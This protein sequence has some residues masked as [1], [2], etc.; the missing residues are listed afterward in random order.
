MHKL[1]SLLTLAAALLAFAP[2]AIAQTATGNIYGN[3]TDQ[4]GAVLPGVSVTLTGETGTRTTVSSAQGQFRLL[5]LDNGDY[6]LA[7]ELNG[8]KKAARKVHVTTGENVEINMQMS[9]SGIAETVEVSAETPL[10]DTKKRGTSTTLTTEELQDVPNARDPWGVLRT[11]P[12]VLV[13]RVNIAG[14]ENGQQAN[15]SSKGSAAADR[16][17]NLDGLNVT[18]MSATGSSPS[19]FDFG[20]FQEINVTTGGSDLTVQSGGMGINLVTKRG[21]NKFH[22]AARYL[23][24][25]NK[26]SFNN[27][28]SQLAG[29]P[30]LAGSGQANHIDQI[31]DYGAELGGPIIKDK[32]WFYGT[33]GKQD[34]R[35]R[36]LTQTPDKTLLPSYNVKLNWQATKDTM[37]SAFYFLGGKQK[38]GRDPGLPV[39]AQDSFLWNQDN[40]YSPDWPLP[41]GLWKL[42]INQTFSPNFYVSAKAAY[43]DTGF[44][45]QPRGGND[46]SYTADYVGGIATGSYYTYLSVRPQKSINV[47]GNYFFQG[48]GGSNELKFGFGFRDVTTNSVS[49]YNGNQIGGVI[50]SPT[51]V[52]ALL[53]RDGVVNYGGKYWSGYAG[54]TLTK[55]RWTVNAGVRFDRQTAKNLASDSPANASFASVLPAVSYAG[56]TSNIVDWNSLSPRVGLSYALDEG[57]KT[58]LRASYANY[59]EQLNFGQVAVDANPVSRGFLAY[60]WNDLNHDGVA[61]PNEVNLNNYLYSY[62]INPANPGAVGTTANQADRDRKPKRDQEA[63][64]GIDHELAP[65]FAVGAAYTFRYS[66]DYTYRPRLAGACSDPSNPTAATCPILTVGDYAPNAPVS[67]NGFTAFTYS[68]DA[69]LVA[70]GG[71]GRLRT[72]AP[73]YHTT[74]NGLELTAT[75]RMSNKW[76][77]RVAFSLNN[78]TE[79]WD[80]APFGV[81]QST[82]TTSGSPT[83]EERD[84]LVNGGQVAILSGGSGKAS[85]Y[86]SVKWQVYADALYNLPGGF[87][88]SGSLFARQGGSYPISLNLPAGA[89]GT[90]RALATAAIDTLRYP[91]L[92][93][94]DLRLA[95]TLKTGGSSSLTLSAEWFNVF[96]SG[97]VL[98]RYRFANSSAFTDTA[99][100]AEPGLGRIE[101]ILAPGIF[102][103][104]A[105]FTF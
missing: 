91:T 70:A 24:A 46:Q 84:P 40:A 73:G 101:E 3:V 62:N 15:T 48:L 23:L 20:A 7:F 35:L 87:D 31:S 53:W 10:V 55:G 21:T 96:N 60:Q 94:L 61:Q 56:D 95:K 99:A 9:V 85:F 65:N 37:V 104:G 80:T 2:L 8:F 97:T 74:F 75:K 22:G 71:A 25:H 39:T 43:Y 77:G 44:G 11:V 89:D 69:A 30:R 47:D 68:P 93:D 67:S 18:D 59:A 88:V 32:L 54:D 14:S 28:P 58:V 78:W 76:F 79:H 57:R 38:F 100:G 13:D 41:G 81:G 92:W 72:N 17:W 51:S 49:H 12:G 82:T 1:R 103:L 42:E 66:T 16:M 19:Y 102:R 63:I 90:E 5:N 26:L 105:R 33:W 34:I 52:V 83:R 45:F 50:N 6:T 36:T 64:L 86:T 27:V 29:D 98:S 4:S